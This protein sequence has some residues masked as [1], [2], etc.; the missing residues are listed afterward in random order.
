LGTNRIKRNRPAA[1]RKKSLKLK[2]RLIFLVLILLSCVYIWQRVTVITLSARTKELKVE[3]NQKQ[4]ACKYL[5]IEVT[6]LSSVKRIEK[7]GKNMGLAYPN[8]DQMGLICES[9]DSTNRKTPGLVKSIWAKLKA[10]QEDLLSGDEAI[11][12]EIKHEP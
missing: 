5:Q 9:S 7:I 1:K 12:K 2:F 10:F 11:A 3:I 8:L 4:K 6:K